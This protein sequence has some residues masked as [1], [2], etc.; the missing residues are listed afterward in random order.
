MDVVGHFLRQ[1]GPEFS[2]EVLAVRPY[3]ELVSAARVVDKSVV[4][5]VVH[6]ACTGAKRYLPLEVREEVDAIVVMMLHDGQ[7]RV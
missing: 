4:E 3:D 5:V 1:V 2:P 7:F 6:N